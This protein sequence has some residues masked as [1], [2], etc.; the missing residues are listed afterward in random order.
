MNKQFYWSKIPGKFLNKETGVEDESLPSVIEEKKLDWVLLSQSET[1]STIPRTMVKVYQEQEVVVKTTLPPLLFKGNVR[2]W[3]ETF[4]MLIF[5]AV[6]LLLK[7]HLQAPKF[8]EVGSDV[9]SIL[10]NSQGYRPLYP[11]SDKVHPGT[12][13][14][15]VGV[16][17]RRLNVIPVSTMDKNKARV[18]LVS[19]HEVKL[20]PN[21][22]EWN[23]AEEF[24]KLVKA[25][26]LHLPILDLKLLPSFTRMDLIEL[27]VMD[28]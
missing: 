21:Q 25:E 10:E 1:N 27:V 20:V 22:K 17:N 8:L 16:L 12:F 4:I 3:N 24:P 14:E 9:F 19:Q 5:D 6:D 15:V 23:S 11:V 26:N 18:V 28:C 13:G 2:A 7:S